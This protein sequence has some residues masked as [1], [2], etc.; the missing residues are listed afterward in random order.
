M[1]L[2]VAKAT[3]PVFLALLGVILAVA[4]YVLLRSPRDDLIEFGAVFLAFVVE[5]AAIV[6]ARRH[7]RIAGADSGL[8]RLALW[9]AVPLV[10]I[11]F[12]GGIG[13]CIAV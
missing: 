4:P 12:L 6:V 10:A 13:P 1:P 7:I 2:S 5:V 11:F 8:S 3:L 9:I